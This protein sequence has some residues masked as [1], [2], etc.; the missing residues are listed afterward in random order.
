MFMRSVTIK[1]SMR[2]KSRIGM[3]LLVFSLMFGARIAWGDT[4]ALKLELAQ[5]LK[6]DMARS[7]A[8]F[9]AA[10]TA[11]EFLSNLQLAV[12]TSKKL[13]NMERSLATRLA[14]GNGQR[15]GECA[16]IRVN[17]WNNVLTGETRVGD[18]IFYGISSKPVNLLVEKEVAATIGGIV[19]ARPFG[20]EW[21]FD[22]NKAFFMCYTKTTEGKY[23][24]GLVPYQTAMS[25]INDKGQSLVRRAYQEAYM[26]QRFSGAQSWVCNYDRHSHASP[27][28]CPHP[29]LGGAWSTRLLPSANPA[30]RQ[31]GKTLTDALK[32][33]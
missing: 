18:P 15:V 23:R 33:P 19:D 16:L 5:Q 21:A 31:S 12:A 10:S 13:D 32:E 3:L 9:S 20:P 6:Q 4:E 28:D 30:G 14:P 1:M 2:R 26:A 27:M 24:R 29:E 17:A 25:H 7:P 22:G 8:A 11:V